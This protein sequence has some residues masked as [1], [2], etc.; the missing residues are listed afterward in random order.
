MRSLPEPPLALIADGF[1][2]RERRDRA[3]A[4]VEAGVRWV[5]ARDHEAS[6]RAF[7]EGVRRLLDRLRA[8]APDV[9]LSVN[10]HAAVAQMLGT[11]VHVGWRGPS[12]AS[13]RPY[14]DDDALVGFSAHRPFDARGHRRRYVDYFFYS[15]VY[16]TAS[17]P[18]HPG[19]GLAALQAFCEVADPV[20]VLAL[21]GI[22]PER[23][24]GCLDAGAAGV[25]VLSGILLADDPAAATRAYRHALGGDAPDRD[26]GPGDSPP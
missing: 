26:P 17:K 15:P 10:T 23:V 22:T 4:A 19:V 25:A 18:R 12:A 3:V 1:T 13:L 20:P 2:A 5:H 16:P 11:S 9:V 7:A 24:Q 21:G 14:F 8:V 6:P